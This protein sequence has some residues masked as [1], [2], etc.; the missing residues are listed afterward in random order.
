MWGVISAM[1]PDQISNVMKNDNVIIH[2]GQHLLKKGG[3]LAKNQHCVHKKMRQMGRPILNGRRVTSLKTSE[4]F[5]VPVYYLYVI[6]A[7]KVT[8]GYD[9]DSNKFTIPSPA[10]KLGHTLVKVSKL[11]K[12]QA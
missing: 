1:V 2:V 11:L 8:C 3:M 10:T 7:V 6:K 4:D 12:A 5:I 9:S